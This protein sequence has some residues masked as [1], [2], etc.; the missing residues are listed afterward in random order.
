MTTSDP[1]SG[2]FEHD[3]DPVDCRARCE[4]C[5][6]DFAHNTTG[7]GLVIAACCG[8]LA[9][10]L[11]RMVGGPGQEG[12]RR[13]CCCVST[14]CIGWWVS[15]A[16][17]KYY[18][19][20]DEPI[21]PVARCTQPLFEETMNKSGTKEEFL[22]SL[23]H[24]DDE[25][26]E[27]SLFPTSYTYDQLSNIESF[28]NQ[29][30][31]EFRERCVEL[32][33]HHPEKQ[34][35]KYVDRKWRPEGSW[36]YLPEKGWFFSGKARD[37]DYDQQCQ[38][39]LTS[40]HRH[41]QEGSSYGHLPVP[42]CCYLCVLICKEDPIIFWNCCCAPII[43]CCFKNQIA[44]AVSR[45]EGETCDK[46]FEELAKHFAKDA[47]LLHQ[48]RG[49]RTAEGRLLYS[50]YGD[51][52]D[53]ANVEK[54]N[55]SNTLHQAFFKPEQPPVQEHMMS[56]VQ[57]ATRSIQSGSSSSS[58][59]DVVLEHELNN[60]SAASSNDTTL[61]SSRQMVG[62][63][64]ENCSQNYMRVAGSLLQFDE[65]QNDKQGPSWIG[66]RMS[67]NFLERGRKEKAHRD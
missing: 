60:T 46:A 23:F 40:S 62:Q 57:E 16:A 48:G 34:V 11:P 39:G 3:D 66:Q 6:S 63:P 27:D 25:F 50:Y 41:L 28:R 36:Y 31:K 14:W 5:L 44:D 22:N 49:G 21:D 18:I 13:G 19:A 10:E 55:V 17:T 8:C 26:D 43:D 67:A 38:N 47:V 52:V 24:H 42:C 30:Q 29:D 1:E 51:I 35:Q 20:Q 56:N 58:S 33:Q 59:R 61:L 64:C 54:D 7:C 2:I 9:N 53:A 45:K 32:M 37:W 65:E 4:N 12:H 15:Q